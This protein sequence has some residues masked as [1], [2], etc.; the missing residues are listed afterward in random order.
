MMSGGLELR[1]TGFERW[2]QGSSVVGK[3]GGRKEAFGRRGRRLIYAAMKTGPQG[4]R[5][6]GSATDSELVERRWRCAPV[7]RE[8]YIGRLTGGDLVRFK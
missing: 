1:L 2:W 5:Q 3:N 4:P 7:A 6:V 8:A